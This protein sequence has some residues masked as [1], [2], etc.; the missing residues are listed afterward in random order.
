[1]SVNLEIVWEGL[2]EV[3][4]VPGAVPGRIAGSYRW[5]RALTVDEMKRMC[6]AVESVESAHRQAVR[7][8]EK[9]GAKCE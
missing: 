8:T 4:G 1:M 5:S 9:A 6:D 7:L 3:V 2:P